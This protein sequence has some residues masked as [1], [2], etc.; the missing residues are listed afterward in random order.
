MKRFFALILIGLLAMLMAACGS[1]D[2]DSATINMAVLP[3]VS[4]L[5]ALWLMDA[6]EN[7]ETE[8]TYNIEIL[9][10]PDEI[11]PRIA[12]GTLDIA[13]IPT[14]MASIIYNN[15]GDVTVLALSTLG[16]LHVIDATNEVF[17]IEDLRGRTVH[18]SGLGATPEFAFNHVLRQSG[19]EPNV[20]V[21]LEF[22]G[23]QHQIAA[24]LAQGMA[25]IALLPEPFATTVVTQNPSLR[26]ALDLSEEWSRVSPDY[27]LVMTAIIVRNEF[28]AQNP[29]AVLLFLE[30]FEQSIH[31]VNNSQEAAA[32]LA[33]DFGLISNV[34]IALQAIPRS[35]QVFITGQRMQQYLSGY[36]AVL[37]SQ[38][39][40]SIGGAMPDADFYFTR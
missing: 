3:G 17:S 28:L 16:V 14:N 21:F 11:P 1:A 27:A 19:L 12:Q 6:A 8:N 29:E 36:L 33:V 15:I 13:A 39:P 23:E 22:H 5:G 35:N 9:G 25:E 30:D 40:A 37:Y 4:A 26:H 32:Q 31:F 2:P 7:G 24:L 20:D 10:T 18:L 34:N 38:L